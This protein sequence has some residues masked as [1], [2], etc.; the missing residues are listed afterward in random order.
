MINFD[1]FI[2]RIVVFN[3]LREFSEREIEYFPHQKRNLNVSKA[4][5]EEL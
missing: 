3:C 1:S 5:S 4:T 2:A